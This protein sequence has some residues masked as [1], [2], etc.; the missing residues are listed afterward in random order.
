M[1]AKQ[2]NIIN[3]C[4]RLIAAIMIFATLISLFSCTP[5]LPYN[6]RK[7]DKVDRRV[8]GYLYEVFLA[9][10]VVRETNLRTGAVKITKYNY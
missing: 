5:S 1:T 4:V 2:Y 3:F 8:K 6:G 7:A 9:D 10:S